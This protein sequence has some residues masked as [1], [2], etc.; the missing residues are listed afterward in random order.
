M[1]I[2]TSLVFD[3]QLQVL[4]IGAINV[5]VVTSDSKVG[6]E[7]M[8]LLTNVDN[9][10]AGTFFGTTTRLQKR[11]SHEGRQQEEQ[12]SPHV[13]DPAERAVECTTKGRRERGFKANK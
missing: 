3:E 10:V 8:T 13:E 7:R 11:S 6:L 5:T 9:L 1:V 4:Q 2:R 12:R